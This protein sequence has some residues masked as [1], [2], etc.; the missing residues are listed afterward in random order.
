MTALDKYWKLIRRLEN[1]S[2]TEAE[3]IKEEL[4]RLKEECE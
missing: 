4:R 2:K 1:A 3:A